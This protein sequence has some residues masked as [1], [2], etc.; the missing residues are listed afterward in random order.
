[1][2]NKNYIFYKKGADKILSIY[3]FTIMLIT[4]IGIFAMIYLFYSAPYDVRVAEADILSDKI[5]DCISRYGKINQNFISL[6]EEDIMKFC[7][8]NFQ[9]E[10]E[11]G[12]ENNEQYFFEIEIKKI[13]FPRF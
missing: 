9:T 11:Y 4:A 8:L 5:A 12:W 13:K 6:K 10:K 1:M 2:V 3:W 7:S